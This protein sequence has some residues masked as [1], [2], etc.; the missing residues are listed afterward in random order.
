LKKRE[1]EKERKKR[2]EKEL[3]EEKSKAEK[4]GEKKRERRKKK[5]H[6]EQKEKRAKKNLGIMIFANELAISA[7]DAVGGNG[8][9]GINEVD[10]VGEKRPLGT[11]VV[12]ILNISAHCLG[13]I[14]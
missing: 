9:H 10:L 8:F 2:R 11:W 6:Q 1:K 7:K 4:E 13:L 5:E 3:K 14:V 12:D